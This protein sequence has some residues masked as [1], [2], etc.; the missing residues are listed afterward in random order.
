M[1]D[2]PQRVIWHMKD[3]DPSDPN[4]MLVK[5]PYDVGNTYTTKG[6]YTLIEGVY[7]IRVKT[8]SPVST[9]TAAVTVYK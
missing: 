6:K 3:E 9:Q 2:N 1:Q 5:D 4:A 8:E 7:E